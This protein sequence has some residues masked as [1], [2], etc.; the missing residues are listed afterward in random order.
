MIKIRD[1]DWPKCFNVRDL[2]GLPLADGGETKWGVVIRSDILS[3]LT[4]EGRRAML[5]YGVRTVIDLRGPK[6]VQK[7]PYDFGGETAESIGLTY[8]NMPLEHFYPHVG[9]L[10]MQAKSRGE[11]YCIILDHYSDLIAEVLRAI[12]NAVPGG[13]VIHCHAGKDRTGTISALLLRLAGVP[14]EVVA[15]DYAES[16]ERLWPLYEKI[17]EEAGGEDKVGFWAKPTVTDEMMLMMLNHVDEKY[18]GVAGYLKTAGLSTV[19]IE[20]LRNILA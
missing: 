2:G 13:V 19:E 15:A 16:Q 18:G 6:E 7:Y 10:I 5:D 8:K 4:D 20:Q 3:R 1:L 11:V 17:V 9:E 12:M 14:N